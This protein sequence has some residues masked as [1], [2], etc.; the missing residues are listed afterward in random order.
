M[1]AEST[2]VEEYLEQMHEM[3]TITAIQVRSGLNAGS[4]IAC[5]CRHTQLTRSKVVLTPVAGG[6]K[7]DHQCIRGVHG[8]LHDS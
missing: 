5:A 2:S 8:R 1:P 7:G 3:T 4:L 6:P